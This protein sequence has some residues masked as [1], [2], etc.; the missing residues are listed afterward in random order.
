MTLSARGRN[1]G[2]CGRPAGGGVRRLLGDEFEIKLLLNQ[3]Q[4]VRRRAEWRVWGVGRRVRGRPGQI[5]HAAAPSVNYTR[6]AACVGPSGVQEPTASAVW[7]E[8]FRSGGKK[9]EF[10]S[11][12]PARVAP[13]ANRAAARAP[14][15]INKQGSASHLPRLRQAGGVEGVGSGERPGS[16]SRG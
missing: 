3:R 7:T 4:R 1:E 12:L 6:P 5:I 8:T 2:N 9:Q 14:G 13:S 10:L 11:F 16:E 15:E